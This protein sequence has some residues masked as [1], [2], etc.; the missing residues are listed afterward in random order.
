MRDYHEERRKREPLVLELYGL[1]FSVQEVA[2]MKGWSQATITLDVRR[3]KHEGAF[4]NRPT[5]SQVFAAVIKRWAELADGERQEGVDELWEILRAHPYVRGL[6]AFVEGAVAHQLALE[7]VGMGLPEGY[8]KLLATLFGETAF[9]MNLPGSN[10]EVGLAS[11]CFADFLKEVRAGQVP[12]TSTEARWRLATLVRERSA[13]GNILVRGEFLT[14]RLVELTEAALRMLSP[15]EEMVIRMRFGIDREPMTLEQV[16]AQEN[17]MVN[18]ER[19]RQIEAKAILKLRHPARSKPIGAGIVTTGE[20]DKRCAQAEEDLAAVREEL[21]NLRERVVRAG[22]REFSNRK[23]YPVFDMNVEDLDLTV[24]AANC[25][26]HAGIHYVGELVQCSE[27][28]MLKTKNF[29]RKCLKQLKELLAKL[30]PPLTLDMKVE[31][32]EPPAPPVTP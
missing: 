30:T 11:E 6:R 26:D 2:R 32:W 14:R 4:V 20:L 13:L 22:F 1:G 7:N 25:L 28:E 8:R 16:G 24:R 29:G 31:N 19:V 3:L 10:E 18:R 9:F 5:K 12:K 21:T 23:P 27:A 17:I 15:R